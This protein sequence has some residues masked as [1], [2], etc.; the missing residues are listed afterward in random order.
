VVLCESVPS[1]LLILVGIH[2]TT[3]QVEQKAVVKLLG[4]PLDLV[5][6]DDT[7]LVSVDTATGGPKE[8]R[9]EQDVSSAFDSISSQISTR[10]AH[11]PSSEL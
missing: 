4:N 1:V 6:V 10:F 9:D 8:N 3:V 7:L 11:L 2:G 5:L